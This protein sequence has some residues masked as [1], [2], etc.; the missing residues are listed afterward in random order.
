MNADVR[1]IKTAAEQGLVETFALA[2][3]HLPGHGKVAAL[4]EAAFESFDSRGLPHRRVEEWKYTD[5]RTLMREARPLAAP[6]D[7]A[8]RLR[9]KNAGQALA[10][11]DRRRI[12]MIDGVFAPELSDLSGLEKGLSIRSLAEALVS[13]EDITSQLGRNMAMSSD[14]AVALN[15]ALMGD[16]AVVHI[17][18]GARIERPLHLIF[19]VTGDRPVSMFARS[20]VVVG[21]EAKVTLIESYEGPRGVEYQLN[22]VIELAAGDDAEIAHI[23]IIDDG[24]QALHI[25]TLLAA[26]GARAKYRDFSFVTGGG[27]VRNQFSLRFDGEGTQAQIRGASLLRG[28]QHLDTTF[29]G[30]H[31]KGHCTGQELFRAVLDGRS[32]NVFQG[33]IIV[34]QHA[35]KT[36]SKM[37]TNALLLSEEA[38]ADNKPELE[39]FADDVVCGHG[40]TAGALD[41]E[42]LFYL[43]AR[44]IP[45][46]E[47]ESLLIQAFVGEVLE[48]IEH[49]GVRE[50]LIGASVTWLK[51]RA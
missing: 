36:D 2:K 26:I 16:G 22:H 33:K 9:A 30:D 37:M 10:G 50:A 23:K 46:K 12:V 13:D 31:A 45:A 19:V 5:L 39:I 3:G 48:A 6:P 4:R 20:L 42:L 44:G 41:E 47:A 11:I 43:K 40:A 18:A 15:T 21:S 29:V 51:G 7:A 8:A 1:Q 38:E 25:S 49:D 35:Q 34:R 27:I 32:R 17:A 28:K 24:D 14:P